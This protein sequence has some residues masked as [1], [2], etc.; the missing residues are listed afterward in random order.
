MRSISVT[1]VEDT[2]DPDPKFITRWAE[3]YVDKLLRD[4]AEAKE[5]SHRFLPR[6]KVDAVAEAARVILKKKGYKVVD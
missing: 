3:I 4:K 2:V 1:M 6:D 5:W